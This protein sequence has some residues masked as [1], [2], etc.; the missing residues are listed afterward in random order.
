METIRELD[1][2]TPGIS[3]LCGIEVD[4]LADG[5]LDLPDESLARLDFV[6]ASIHS[7]F[8]QPRARI[9]KRLASAMENPFVRSIGHPTGRLLGRR[10]PY[11]VDLE[12]LACMAAETGTYLEINA[13]YDRLDLHAAAVRRAVQLGAKIVI[14]ADAHHRGDFDN[15]KFGVWEGRR[16]WLEAKDVANTRPLAQFRTELRQ[17]N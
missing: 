4:I 16:G 17:A 11:D 13:S 3:L 14:C 2:R 6:T 5:R 1:A 15:L 9:M 12:E 7:G 8:G 10:E